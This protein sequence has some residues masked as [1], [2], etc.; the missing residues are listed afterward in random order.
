M[1]TVKHCNVFVIF[2]YSHGGIIPPIAKHLH[3]QHITR[4]LKDAMSQANVTVDDLDAIATTVK[5]GKP[6]KYPA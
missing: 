6:V 2:I 1:F 4:I 3:E 5:P